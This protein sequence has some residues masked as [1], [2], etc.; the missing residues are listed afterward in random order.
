MPQVWTC[1]FNRTWIIK[2]LS[3]TNGVTKS[4]KAVLRKAMV[5]LCSW[6][7][8]A[9]ACPGTFVTLKGACGKTTTT[10]SKHTLLQS[11]N[12]LSSEMDQ[13]THRLQNFLSSLSGPETSCMIWTPSRLVVHSAAQQNM[14]FKVH[15]THKLY[16]RSHTIRLF[17][18]LFDW[19]DIF[20]HVWMIIPKD[21]SSQCSVVKQ[22]QACRAWH[23][24]PARLY[25]TCLHSAISFSKKYHTHI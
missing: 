22:T 5:Q 15:N 13:S 11:T 24:P 16:Q 14:I 1:K 7:I 10:V 20:R 19:T 18:Y 21:T 6:M 9:E 23:G 12:L 4:P 8:P 3:N 25:G 2:Q 17:V